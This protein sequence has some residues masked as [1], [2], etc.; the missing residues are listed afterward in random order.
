MVVIDS[1]AGLANA[2]SQQRLVPMRLFYD[3]LVEEGVRQSN[4]AALR[5]GLRD[6]SE[7]ADLGKRT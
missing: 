6:R 3:V 5:R 2:T 7:A 4:P 1:G